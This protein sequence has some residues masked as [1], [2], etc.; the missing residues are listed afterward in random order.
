MVIQIHE[1]TNYPNPVHVGAVCY[2]L[3]WLYTCFI[4][5]IQL[6]ACD[7]TAHTAIYMYILYGIFYSQVHTISGSS[8]IWFQFG[9]W[10]Y[11]SSL[12]FW[13]F[14]FSLGSSLQFGVWGQSSSLVYGVIIPVWCMGSFF[15]FGVWGSSSLVCEVIPSNWC[16]S[17]FSLCMGSSFQFGY[18][19]ILQVL[20]AVF[21]LPVLIMRSILP[22]KCMW[23]FL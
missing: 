16:L 10:G 20:W 23:T 9:A 13:V 22:V 14:S 12:L 1:L 18:K 21:I 15:Q 2:L 4:D 11:S 17:I 5:S 19:V 3:T 8:F 7:I 6:T